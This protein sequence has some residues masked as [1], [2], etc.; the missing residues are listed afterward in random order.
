MESGER[1][2]GIQ[3]SAQGHKG[4]GAGLQRHTKVN[5]SH[6]LHSFRTVSYL[7]K[8]MQL[9]DTDAPCVTDFLVLSPSPPAGQVSTGMGQ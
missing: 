5:L 4:H 3:V 8:Q 2:V 7:L 9:Q 6:A 1:G